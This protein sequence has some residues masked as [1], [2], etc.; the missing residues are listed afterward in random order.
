MWAARLGIAAVVAFVVGPAIAHFRLVPPLAGFVVFDLGGLLG[1]I[2]LVI[3]IVGAVRGRGAGLG[4][5]LGAVTTVA[6]FAIASRG[7]GVPRIN[8]ITTDTTNPPQFVAAG[9]LDANRGR[10][11]TYPGPTFAEQQ[12]A[13]YPDL[14]PLQ[15]PGS[16]DEVF[17]RIDA[18]ARQVATWQITR[19]DPATHALEGVDTSAVFRFQDDFVIEVRPQDGG[20]VVQMRSKSRDG[21]GDLGANAARIKAFFAKLQ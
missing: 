12:R 19:S 2:A 14:A 21:K 20:S 16:P 5:A 17:K 8:D 1:L 4:L 13:G 10:D 6:F 9:S 11:M 3:G 15:L 18:A 7:G